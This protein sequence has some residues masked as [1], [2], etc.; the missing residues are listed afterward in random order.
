METRAKLTA[1]DAGRRSLHSVVRGFAAIDDLDSAAQKR[2]LEFCSLQDTMLMSGRFD[3]LSIRF[4]S[5][6]A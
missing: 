4:F 2:S 6:E 3:I 1:D 5:D